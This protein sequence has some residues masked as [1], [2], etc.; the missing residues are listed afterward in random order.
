MRPDGLTE[1]RRSASLRPAVGGLL[2]L[3]L[4]FSWVCT[5]TTSTSRG[6]AHHVEQGRLQGLKS[7]NINTNC[8]DCSV[9]AGRPHPVTDSAS[10]ST[11]PPGYEYRAAHPLTGGAPLGLSLSS[12]EL[13]HTSASVICLYNR[14]TM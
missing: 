2:L 7:V 6:K 10:S 14:Q 1:W 12:L 9:T 5:S 3:Q 8:T 4:C 11:L 13:T